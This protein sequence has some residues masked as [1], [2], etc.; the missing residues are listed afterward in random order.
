MQDWNADGSGFGKNFWI[1][2]DPDPHPRQE[3]IKERKKIRRETE[4]RSSVRR[5]D[6]KFIL[7]KQRF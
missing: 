5:I 3:Y 4:I 2:S 7:K 1:L 6:N